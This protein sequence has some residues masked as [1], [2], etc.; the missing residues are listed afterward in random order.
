MAGPRRSYDSDDDDIEGFGGEP[1]ADVVGDD[2]SDDDD[3][4]E[5]DPAWKPSMVNLC[6]F[7]T[8]L[9]VIVSTI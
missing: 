8:V 5:D 1:A 2:D 9:S 3:D 6:Y 7:L 4:D